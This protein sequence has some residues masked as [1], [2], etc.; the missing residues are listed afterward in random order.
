MSLVHYLR[1]LPLIAASSLFLITLVWC[2]GSG[3]L[4]EKLIEHSLEGTNITYENGEV[5]FNLY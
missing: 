5:S 3:N 1:Y 4:S 2:I